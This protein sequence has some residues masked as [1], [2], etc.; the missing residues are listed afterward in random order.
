MKE[1]NKSSNKCDLGRFIEAQIYTYDDVIS[2]LTFG[3]KQGH[4][5][6][7]IFPQIEGLGHSDKAKYYAIKNREE[8]RQYLDH[9][10]LGERLVKCT[11]L[12]VDIEGRSVLE[13]FGSPDDRK[14]KSSM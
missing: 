8:T 2:E 3:Q 13:I 1:T 9:S 4:W 14:F 10:I 6:W 11:E 7:F 5:M 12:V